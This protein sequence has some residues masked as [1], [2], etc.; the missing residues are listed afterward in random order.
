MVL[1]MMGGVGAGH[2]HMQRDESDAHNV[3]GRVEKQGTDD[4]VTVDPPVMSV[5][6]SIVSIS[7]TLFNDAMTRV[8]S[9]RGMKAAKALPICKAIEASL[10]L[11]TPMPIAKM[12]AMNTRHWNC[13]SQNKPHTRTH[14]KPLASPL[15]CP[16]RAS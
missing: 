2:S 4:I 10:M 9:S 8:R 16:P 14:P 7:R 15:S 12:V 5:S 13:T 11:V 6:G 1:V 3:V